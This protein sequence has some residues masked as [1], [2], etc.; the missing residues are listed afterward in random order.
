MYFQILTNKRCILNFRNHLRIGRLSTS[1]LF[2]RQ[3][4][5]VT[6]NGNQT[7]LTVSGFQLFFSFAGKILILI[8]A[9]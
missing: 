9:C 6:K 5:L 1:F 7:N 3:I 2:W 4:N 8:G